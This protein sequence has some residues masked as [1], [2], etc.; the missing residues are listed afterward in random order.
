MTRFLKAVKMKSIF[1][2]MIFRY[3]G[4][5][6]TSYNHNRE[7]FV[8]GYIPKDGIGLLKPSYTYWTIAYILTLEGLSKC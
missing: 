8:P 1:I 7:S 4:R 3:L 2:Q 5:Q 6:L